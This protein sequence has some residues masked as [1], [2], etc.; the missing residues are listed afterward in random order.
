MGSFIAGVI[1][2]LFMGFLANRLGYLS[3]HKKAEKEPTGTGG[4]GGGGYNRENHRR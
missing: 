4:S 2:A 1:F 3:V